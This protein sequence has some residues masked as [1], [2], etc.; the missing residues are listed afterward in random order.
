MKISFLNERRQYKPSFSAGLTRVQQKK[1]N[2]IQKAL[3]KKDTQGAYHC[4]TGNNNQYELVLNNTPKE[5]TFQNVFYD[6]HTDTFELETIVQN[7]LNQ[8]S[9]KNIKYQNYLEILDSNTFT[10]Q[11]A[12][13]KN[14]P[15]I[16]ILTT[17][18]DSISLQF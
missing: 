3:V 13:V 18:E 9:K 10:Y 4:Q 8:S 2:I 1:Y 12:H 6:K 5:M 7:I 11:R 14:T 17:Q 15:N 16:I